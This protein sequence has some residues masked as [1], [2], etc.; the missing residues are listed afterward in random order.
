M[1]PSIEKVHSLSEV[2]VFPSLEFPPLLFRLELQASLLASWLSHMFTGQGNLLLAYCTSLE[3]LMAASSLD[4]LVK[5]RT[6]G[7]L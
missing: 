3:G 6:R 5:V 2:F 4:M 7:S 1:I